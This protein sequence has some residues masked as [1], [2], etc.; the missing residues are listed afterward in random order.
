MAELMERYRAA[1]KDGDLVVLEGLH[2][3]KHALRFG[4]ELL[5]AATADAD[6]LEVL[7]SRLCPDVRERILDLVEPV[8]APLFRTL[9]PVPPD[10]GVMALACRP[11]MDPAALLDAA[12]AAP[13][14]LLEEP[15]HPGNVGAAVRVAAAAGAAGFL[16]LGMLDPWRPAAVRG[17]AGL[18]FALP[19]R[20]LARLP[21]HTRPL[22]AVTADGS[23]LR[24]G[25]LPAR[26]LLAFGS[27]RRGLS[28]ELRQ[29][30]ALTVGIPM[31]EGVSSLNLATAVAVALYMGG[32][33]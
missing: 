10:T 6:A 29:A 21:A 9:A 33:S 23:P 27:E 25:T 18:Q 30:A 17:G 28:P 11:R 13:V 7:A 20:R 31:R 5:H 12:G 14:V 3:L 24:S 8:D 26:A 4:A 2:A 32:G 1:R 15:S 19:T 22:V 16:V